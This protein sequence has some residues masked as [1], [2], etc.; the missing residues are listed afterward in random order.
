[1]TID[2][3]AELTCCGELPKRLDVVQTAPAWSQ[4]ER[5]MSIR[6]KLDAMIFSQFMRG[7]TLSVRRIVFLEPPPG[8]AE[9][10][11][12]EHRGW[13]RGLVRDLYQLDMPDRGK[14][15][16]Y[17][18]RQLIREPHPA[19]S[20]DLKDGWSDGEGG[21]WSRA[22]EQA[23]SALRAIE[24]NLRPADFPQGPAA[25]RDPRWYLWH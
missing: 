4:N 14:K 16:E 5:W 9:R 1:M 12:E 23:W 3:F 17:R 15:G 22:F 24:N 18:I 20:P 21:A 19:E 25:D 10:V 8:L 7:R 11:A 13:V 2:E 6:D